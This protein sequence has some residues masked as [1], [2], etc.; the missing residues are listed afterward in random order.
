MTPFKPVQATGGYDLIFYGGPAA[1][2]TTQAD[3]LANSLGAKHISMGEE[4]RK[5]A[6]LNNPLGQK[7]RR[8]MGQG[9]LLSNDISI[10]VIDAVL[11]KSRPKQLMIFDG[12]P[13]NITQAR[14]LDSYLKKLNRKAAMVYLD[15]PVEV[16]VKRLHLRGREDDKSDVAVRNRIGIFL[17]N[18]ERMLKYYRDTGRLLDIDGHQSITATNR[19][20]TKQLKSWS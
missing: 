7:I 6:K 1:G 12:F 13:R 2:K 11:Q 9:K 14:L 16:A 18:A 3:L 10:A 15:V 20:I 17:R 8:A 19:Q 5:L 4:L